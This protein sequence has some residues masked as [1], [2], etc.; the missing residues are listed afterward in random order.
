MV[1]W[2]YPITHLSFLHFSSLFSFCSS[3]LI[4]SNDWSL[5][6]P[7]FYFPWSSLMLKHFSGFCLIIIFSTMICFVLL[8]I[9]LFV[10]FLLLSMH[11]VPDLSEHLSESYFQF[12]FRYIYIRLL[13]FFG[14]GNGKPLQYSCSILAWRIPWT[15]KPGVL[16]S[17]GSQRHDWV[18][19]TNTLLPFFRVSIWRFISSLFWGNILA[20]LLIFLDFLCCCLHIR[21]SRCLSQPS[22]TDLLQ[23]KT[24]TYQ[25]G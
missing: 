12:S 15:E 24:T 19:N 10:Q 5:N 17:M 2:W 18:T 13:L 1:S 7:V 23:E 14:E 20:W 6:S 16:Q 21:Q 22:W 8:N 4:I 11:C 9:F 25:L 3:D